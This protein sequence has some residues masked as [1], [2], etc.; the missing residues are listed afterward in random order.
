MWRHIIIMSHTVLVILHVCNLPHNILIVSRGNPLLL[1]H[2]L[3]LFLLGVAVIG[4]VVTMESY[5]QWVCV[6]AVL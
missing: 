6:V 5:T 3:F 4:S 1:V 2:T